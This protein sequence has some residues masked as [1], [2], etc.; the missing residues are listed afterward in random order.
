[1]AEPF[2]KSR[3]L[4]RG[5]RRYRRKIASPKQWAAIRASLSTEAC[6]VC[7]NPFGRHWQRMQAHH[8]VSRAALGDDEIDNL[9]PLHE[10]C[11]KLV[12]ERD[13]A[14]LAALAASVQESDA[15]YAY[16]VGKLGEGGMERLFGVGK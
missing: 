6:F 10:E 16:V 15:R 8:L 12:T 7:G 14:T 9:V 4:A 11:H 3:Q 5:E 1:M 2:P 13:P